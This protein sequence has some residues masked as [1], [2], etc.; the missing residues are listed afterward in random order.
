MLLVDPCRRD[1]EDPLALEQ[2]RPSYMLKISDW[3]PL[4]SKDHIAIA[5]VD[6]CLVGTP[7]TAT[8]LSCSLLY[9]IGPL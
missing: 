4:R 9:G 8:R 6:Q 3:A 1:G 7:W 2:P 5:D